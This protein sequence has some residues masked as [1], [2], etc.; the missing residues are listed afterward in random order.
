MSLNRFLYSHYVSDSVSIFTPMFD[1]VPAWNGVLGKAA[2]AIQLSYHVITL[3]VPMHDLPW[4]CDC[5]FWFLSETGVA[6][7]DQSLSHSLAP[8]PYVSNSSQAA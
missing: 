2:F 7:I 4:F 3:Q 5:I 8:V 1:P 6:R